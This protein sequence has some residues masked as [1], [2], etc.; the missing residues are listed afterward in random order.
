MDRFSPSD[1]IILA[2][3]GYLFLLAIVRA[4]LMILFPEIRGIEHTKAIADISQVIVGAIVGYVG[5][6]ESK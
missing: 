3:T 5:G 4:G 2:L 1:I 6:R